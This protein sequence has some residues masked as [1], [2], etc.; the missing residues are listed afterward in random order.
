MLYFPWRNEDIDLLADYTD[1]ESHYKDVLDQI[2]ANEEKF[3]ENLEL[4]DDAIAQ[5]ADHGPP[6]HAWAN[7]APETEHRRIIDEVEGTEVLRDMEQEDLDANAALFQNPR[8][9]HR[10][11]ISAR[12]DAQLRKD[13]LQPKEY[14]SMVRGL[15]VKQREVVFYHRRWCKDVVHAIKMN[16]PIT[17]YRLFLSGPGGVG[18]SHMIRLIHTDTRKLLPLSNTIKPSDLTVLLTAPTGVAAFNIE[19]MT[20]HSALLLQTQRGS[21]DS[22]QLSFEKLNSLRSKLENLQLLIIDEVSMVGA[23]MLLNI[24]RRLDEIKGISGDN[25]WF[26]NVSVLAVGDLY[27]LPPVAQRPIY[28]EV[29]DA[30]ARLHG[31]GS[32]WKDEFCLAEL[33]EIMRQKNDQSFAELLC[34]VRTGQSTDEDIETL[35]SREIDVNDPNYPGDILHVFAYNN[36]VNSHNIKK[37][38]MIASNEQ[39]VTIR[40]F[41]D[42]KDSTGLIDL[43]KIKTPKT[44][45]VTGGLE[46]ELIIAVGARV[47]MTMNVDTADGLVNG[48]TGEVV[49]IKRNDTDKVSVI[50]VKFDNIK[51]GQRA[52]E[53]SQWKIQYPN[54]VPVGRHQSRYDKAN[55]KGATTAIVQFPLTL[56][57]AVTIHKCQGLTMDQVVVSLQGGSKL[58]FGQAYVA[59]S[60]VKSLSGLYIINFDEGAI[61]T[62]PAINTEMLEMR[63][64]MLPPQNEACITR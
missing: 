48:V 23:D 11:E 64:N 33:D 58:S 40:S 45:N 10:G 1:F 31:S 16:K 13:I 6:E 12:Y 60:R 25:I 32:I 15:N 28:E 9:E 59:F 63:N 50:L 56:A 52:I 8:S 20:I 14:R 57:W 54:A 37:L 3:N 18:K 42:G 41:E 55:K 24:H 38:N 46:R 51:V 29:G 34:R 53:S 21:N 39:Q 26:G 19:G 27:Q 62:N 22:G 30:M 17:P 36:A 47:M 5:N 49:A 7:I 35:K 44:R 2:T 43:N 61:K 4:I